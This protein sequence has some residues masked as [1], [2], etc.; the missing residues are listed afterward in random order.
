MVCRLRV[1]SPFCTHTRAPP[2]PQADPTHPEQHSELTTS[3]SNASDLV[4]AASTAMQARHNKTGAGLKKT[5][6]LLDAQARQLH[7]LRTQNAEQG[8]PVDDATEALDVASN[9]MAAAQEL[10]K[11]VEAQGGASG[12]VVKQFQHAAREAAEATSTAAT[13]MQARAMKMLGN[14]STPEVALAAL[15]RL[16]DAE[17]AYQKMYRIFQ[18]SP[19]LANLPVVVQVVNSATEDLQPAR[20]MRTYVFAACS[21]AKEHDAVT[22]IQAQVRRV[23]AQKETDKKRNEAKLVEAL[24]KEAQADEEA[25]EQMDA[26]AT[27]LQALARG[28][29]ARR[30]VRGVTDVWRGG[31]LDF[32]GL[33]SP[34]SPARLLF[35]FC[36]CIVFACF[37]FCFCCCVSWNP[38]PTN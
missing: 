5:M 15:R 10:R 22:R 31:L 17:I 28:R 32:V 35:G 37:C 20:E 38:L 13:A 36:L 26:A 24:S 30:Q 23:K 3:L 7:A 9:K 1:A 12:D 16:Y 4:A 25:K 27:R 18:A 34:H 19:V 11:L 6:A 33:G 21:S 29:A 8:I 2:T 14:R